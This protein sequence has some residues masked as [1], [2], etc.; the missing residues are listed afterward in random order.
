MIFRT[1]FASEFVL[2]LLLGLVFCVV[3][4]P[5]VIHGQ[6]L[7][8]QVPTQSVSG[9]HA[10]SSLTEAKNLVDNSSIE[11]NA[12]SDAEKIG[13]LQETLEEDRKQ[14]AE[15]E[16]KIE[17]PEDEY[18]LA[19]HA[20]RELNSDLDRETQ[21][22]SA[23]RTSGEVAAMKR[24]ELEIASIERKRSLAEARF[25]LAIEDKKRMREQAQTLRGKIKRDQTALDDITGEGESN[26]TDESESTK[27]SESSSNSDKKRDSD[28]Q[29]TSEGDSKESMSDESSAV[30]KHNRSEPEDEEV[31]EAEHLAEE[32]ESEADEAQQETQSLADRI[33]DLQKLIS[34]EQKELQLARKKVVLVDSAQ[35]GLALEV[36]KRQAENADKTELSELR[37]EVND[38]SRRL[39][40]A[41]TAV[42]TIIERLNDHRT[43]LGMLQSE[44]IV[45]LHEA[46]LRRQEANA[47]ESH[48]ES[49]RNPFAPRNILKLI[50]DHGVRLVLIVV[51]MFLL[52]RI[53]SFFS[54]RS[55][56][57]VSSGTS[58]GSKTEREN[59]AKTLVGVFQNAAT[60]VIF[61]AGFLMILEEAGANVTVLMGGVAVIGLAVAFGAQNLIKDY[62]YGF[63]ML[64]E[65]QYMLNDSIRIGSLSGQV[66][67]IT[68]RMTV[69]RDSNGIVH[70]VPNGTI[71]AVSN[72]T[73]G[74]SRAVCE[75][76]IGYDEDL[77]QTMDALRD[78]AKGLH[79]DAKFG[80]LMMES[81]KDLAID[82]LGESSI[83]LKM[84][85]KTLP[86]KH[87]A[88]KQEWLRRIKIRFSQ[89]GIQPAYPQRTFRIEPEDH[90][91]ANLIP[92]AR[93]KVA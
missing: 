53:A 92:V 21:A 61:I 31:L 69:L 44:H 35:Q 38:A 82:R 47:A 29:K 91:L 33:V 24:L 19:E 89:L 88:V 3:T 79:E 17:S 16:S 58:R 12:P 85:V 71:E 41:R 48:L 54:Y 30:E 28:S 9:N 81:P 14:L 18:A 15:L 40:V 78:I 74:W 65:N 80:A 20:F 68:L 39:I 45:A 66:E 26:V 87:G 42:N 8:Q 90:V 49:L 7:L 62:F 50:N 25:E 60:V 2:K 10:E 64:L 55:V 13:E 4:S 51:G 36:T 67:R 1:L 34:Q 83:Q 70:F 84:S 37:S 23:A 59:R 93:R 11:A 63:V 76:S 22:L 77:D 27:S 72:E 46:E 43:E 5:Q 6:E 56:R 86:N 32:K 52:N 75:V 73:H 57:L